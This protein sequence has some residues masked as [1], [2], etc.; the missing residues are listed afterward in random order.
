MNCAKNLKKNDKVNEVN[1]FHIA[2]E[3][4]SNPESNIYCKTDSKDCAN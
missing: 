3:K 2:Y 1:I 4:N